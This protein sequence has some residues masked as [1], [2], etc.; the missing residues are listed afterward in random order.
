MN[1]KN[2]IIGK[3]GLLAAGTAVLMI[4]SASAAFTT[5]RT[6]VNHNRYDTVEIGLQIKNIYDED[7]DGTATPNEDIFFSL[8]VANKGAEAYIRIRPEI[9]VVRKDGTE[10]HLETSRIISEDED[11]K[12]D[13]DCF[14]GMKKLKENG[15]LMSGEHFRIP[16]EWGNEYVDGTIRIKVVAEAVQARIFGNE[17]LIESWKDLNVEK[18][19]RSRTYNMEVKQL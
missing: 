2:R 7:K 11:W 1:T 12:K 5:S 19:V 14:Y 9:T 10:T 3:N 15:S 4:A 8:E 16:Q 18:T 6:I 13:G 17:N